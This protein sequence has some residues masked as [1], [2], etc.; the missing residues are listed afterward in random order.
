[1]KG[2]EDLRQDERVMQLFSL[3]NRLLNN[4]P[5]TER[6]DLVI[7]KYSV[8]PLSHNTGIIGWVQ[9][10]DTLQQ[11]IREYRES[12][13]IRSNTESYLMSSFCDKYELLPLANKVE[14]FRNILENTRGEDIQKVTSS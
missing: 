13:Q 9:N 7:T 1:L 8:I 14:I 10:C 6:K 11:L 12:S 2:H 3:V 5:E 4:D